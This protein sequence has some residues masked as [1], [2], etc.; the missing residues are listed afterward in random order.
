MRES[1]LLTQNPFAIREID[2]WHRDINC[3]T[4]TIKLKESD[5]LQKIFVNILKGQTSCFTHTHT[6][7]HTPPQP[8]KNEG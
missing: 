1:F 3:M 7:T 6:H 8:L 4:N 5:K 2:K